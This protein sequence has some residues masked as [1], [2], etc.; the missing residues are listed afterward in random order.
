MISVHTIKP[1]DKDCIIKSARKTKRVVTCENHN[2]IGGL[3]SA[4]SEVLSENYPVIIKSIGIKDRFGQVGKLPYLKKEYGLEVDN[5]VDT[6]I[7]VVNNY[8]I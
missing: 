5:I 3:R 6:C 1:I 7:H 8:E 4:V 2:I